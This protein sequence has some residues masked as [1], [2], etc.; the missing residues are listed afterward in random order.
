MKKLKPDLAFYCI[1]TLILH[2]TYSD[3]K[4]YKNKNRLKFKI[5]RIHRKSRKKRERC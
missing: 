1:D 3:N 2:K 5:V 4:N